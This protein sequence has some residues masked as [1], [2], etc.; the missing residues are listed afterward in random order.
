VGFYEDTSAGYDAAW[1]SEVVH[2]LGT[3]QDWAAKLASS[4][5]PGARGVV[6]TSTHEQLRTR[7]WYTY[8]PRALEVDL[9]RHP[10]EQAVSQA[11]A[12]SGFV[13]YQATTVDESRMLPATVV[14]DL[15]AKRAFSTLHLISARELEAG[16]ALWDAEF[17]GSDLVLWDYEMTAYSFAV[18]RS[19]GEP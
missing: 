11:L 9:E 12:D 18:P 19:E 13:S 15:F 17:A 6:R 16:L 8:F 5:N 3:P 4:L 14:R 10:S 7:H 2:L 1:L